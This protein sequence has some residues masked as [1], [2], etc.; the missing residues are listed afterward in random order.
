MRSWA[1]RDVNISGSPGSGQKLYRRKTF[2]YWPGQCA[3]SAQGLKQAPE[4]RNRWGLAGHKQNPSYSFWPSPSFLPPSSSRLAVRAWGPAAVITKNSSDG[5][6]CEGAALICKVP[7]AWQVA[8]GVYGLSETERLD[9]HFQVQA[10]VPS[11]I[12]S[13]PRTE[14]FVPHYS[15]HS[16]L[17]VHTVGGLGS[18][19]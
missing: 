8:A 7:E 1:G 11:Q 3:V 13:S 2:T 18:D 9:S 10:P 15:S 14:L 6:G 5:F 17:E 4:E 12:S 19:A 16:A